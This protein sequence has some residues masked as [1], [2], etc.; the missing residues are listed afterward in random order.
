M[1]RRNKVEGLVSFLGSWRF[2][3]SQAHWSLA[4]APRGCEGSPGQRK[5]GFR[6]VGVAR[7]YLRDRFGVWNAGHRLDLLAKGFVEDD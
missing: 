6:P 1:T 5:D 2:D 7:Q 4:W 3:S